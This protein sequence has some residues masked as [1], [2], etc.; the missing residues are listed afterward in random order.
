MAEPVTGS[1]TKIRGFET[2]PVSRLAPDHTIVIDGPSSGP[3][4]AIP[5]VIV[6]DGTRQMPLIDT[7]QPGYSE[8]TVPIAYKYNGVDLQGKA[9]VQSL[10]SGS[11]GYY[12]GAKQYPPVADNFGGP[13]Q[14]GMTYYNVNDDK[15]YV[16][17][18]QQK[19]ALG[20]SAFPATIKAFY[21]TFNVGGSMVP[22]SGPGAP[23]SYGNVLAFNVAAGQE[24]INAVNLYLNGTLLVNGVDYIVHEGGANGDYITLAE[25]VC[26]GSVA[27]VQLFSTAETTFVPNAVKVNTSGWVFNDANTTF[28]LVDMGGVTINPGSQ[29]N[30]MLVYNGSV[31]QPGVDFFLENGLIRFPAPPHAGDYVWGTV[32]VPVGGGAVRTIS[33]AAF[34]AVGDGV[35]DDTPMLINAIQRMISTGSTLDLSGGKWRITAPLPQFSQCNIQGLNTGEIYVDFDP[36]GTPILDCK[37][38]PRAEYDVTAISVVDYDFNGAFTA[39]SKLTRVTV[40]TGL[41]LPPVG[42]VCK[43]T[44][45]DAIVGVETGDNVGQHIVVVAVDTG[46]RYVYAAEPII[47]AM[48]TNIKLY[49]LGNQVVNMSGFVMSANWARLVS[50]DWLFEYVR[51]QGAIYPYYE[52]LEFRD[53]V[54]G[55]TEVGCFK[56]I[57][58][59]CRV[60]HMRNATASETPP[61]PGYGIVSGGCYMPLHVDLAA[62][63][64]R[65]GYTTISPDALTWDRM[66]WGRT[67]KPIILAGRGQGC[68]AAAFDTHSDAWEPTFDAC[69]VN[70]GYFGENSAGAGL[71]M[72]GVRGRMIGCEVRGSPVG[73]ELYKQFVGEAAG[74]SIEDCRYYGTGIPIRVERDPGLSDADARSVMKVGNFYGETTHQIG[75]DLS[76]TDLIL[77]GVCKI[78][79]Q[80]TEDSIRAVYQRA[81]STIR[82]E[83]GLLI[84]DISA[85]TGAPT[86][87]LITFTGA[88]CGAPGLLA[89]VIAGPATWQAVVSE[90][91]PTQAPAGVFRINCD[92]D[93]APAAA[94]G[95]YSQNGAGNLLTAGAL[96]L[97]LTINGATAPATQA[98]AFAL[99]AAMHNQTIVCTAAFTVTVPAA[100]VLGPDFRLDLVSTTGNVVLD[101]PGGTNLTVPAGSMARIVVANGVIYAAATAMTVLT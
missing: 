64:C 59:G 83:G 52:D 66:A 43:L 7:T 13:L 40:A 74:H 89:R 72:R 79:H 39:T 47:D 67:I 99:V 36:V 48:T 61:V 50:E 12:L 4:N 68:S 88:S 90:N 81:K 23:D 54:Q 85:A 96:I 73:F 46:A 34:G 26:A 2:P 76:D 87:R 53:G 5:S 91:D 22:P 69:V 82:S 9:D 17:T 37:I 101:G 71:Q 86:P 44:A 1:E 21:Y 31:I 35:A 51:V 84:H 27:V 93:K 80:G 95:G 32:G 20:G 29:N 77:T 94:S 6:G 15:I 58:R 45:E 49:W 98:T 78:A 11:A 62:D 70:G 16:W 25:S 3:G 60:D 24:A 19:W 30:I 38:L 10:L 92:T 41:A 75:I 56:P 42:S 65:H 55:L 14:V 18:S 33:P 28:P 63:D 97:R 100:A 8:V 57:S